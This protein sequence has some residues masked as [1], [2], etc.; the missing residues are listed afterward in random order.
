[1]TN[2]RSNCYN[3][4]ELTRL[5]TQFGSGSCVQN[6]KIDYNLSVTAAVGDLSYKNYGVTS[7]GEI[8][9]VVH[10]NTMRYC[11]VASDGLLER[12]TVEQIDNLVEFLLSG[13]WKDAFDIEEGLQ[14]PTSMNYNELNALASQ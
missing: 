9:N 7:K 8:I 13:H 1:M 12:L 4:R 2:S 6:G 10:D 11:L 3:N 14:S 5:Q